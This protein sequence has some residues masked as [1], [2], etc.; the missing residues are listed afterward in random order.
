MDTFIY[1]R[2]KL[3]PHGSFVH[4]TPLMN[5]LV[6]KFNPFHNKPIKKSISKILKILPLNLSNNNYTVVE[7][8]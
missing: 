5:I 7:L 8:L 4:L 6:N 3:G 1:E 2:V